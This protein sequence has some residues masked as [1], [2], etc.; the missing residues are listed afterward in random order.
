MSTITT[1]LQSLKQQLPAG[2]ELVAV[3]KFHPIEALTEAYQAGQRIFGESRA[4]ELTAKA[5]AM[6]DD[7][8]WHYIAHLQRNKVRQVVAVASMIQSVDSVELLHLIDH[9]AVRAGRHIDVLLQLH[10][11]QESTKT[12]FY[13]ADLLT[14]AVVGE[15]EGLENVTVRGLMC[16]ASLTDDCELIAREFDIAH[17]VYDMLLDTVFD[18]AQFNILS[19]GMTDDWP[20]AV[21][22]GANMVRIGSAIFGPRQY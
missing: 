1:N 10:V 11:S 6:P 7:V 12:G 21:E 19:M 5:Q 16:M 13:M 9:E 2:V 8:Q 15:L 22:H 20:I 4:Q 18:A 3:S 14:A 17:R